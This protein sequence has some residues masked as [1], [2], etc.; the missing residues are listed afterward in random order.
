MNSIKHLLAVG[1]CAGVGVWGCGS[2]ATTNPTGSQ[3]GSAAGGQGGSGGGAT[4][5]GGSGGQGGSGQGGNGQGGS[6]GA[7]SVSFETTSFTVDESEQLVALAVELTTDT[8]L[9]QDLTVAFEVS[10]SATEGEDYALPESFEVTFPEGSESGASEDVPEFAIRPDFDREGDEDVVFA[11]DVPAAVMTGDDA[12]VTI[13]DDDTLVISAIRDDGFGTDVRPRLELHDPSSELSSVTSPGTIGII[14]A[15]S[16]AYDPANDM[17]YIVSDRGQ[18]LFVRVDMSDGEVS[19]VAALGIRAI[20]CLTFD[21]STGTLYGIDDGLDELVEIDTDNGKVTVLGTIDVAGAWEGC[22]YDS[23]NGILYALDD[24]ANSVYSIDTGTAEATLIGE[25][26]VL[27]SGDWEAATFGNGVLYAERNSSDE[28]HSVNTTDGTTTLI[29]THDEEAGRFEGLAYD[30]NSGDLIATDDSNE[31]I[32]TIDT[33]DAGTT[34]VSVLGAEEVESLAYDAANDILYGVDRGG[35]LLVTYNPTNGRLLGGVRLSNVDSLIEALAYDSASNLLFA[36]DDADKVIVTIDPADGTM[37]DLGDP[38]TTLTGLAFKGATLFGT[39]SGALV[40]VNVSDGEAT[41]VGAYNNAS[42]VQGLAYDSNNDRLVALDDDGDVDMLYV[43]DSSDGTDT[44]LGAAGSL[45]VD[46]LA[47]DPNANTLYGADMVR[48]AIVS[49]DDASA[50]IT[51]HSALVGVIAEALAFDSNNQIGYIVEPTGALFSAAASGG[52]STLVGFVELGDSSTEVWGLA[53]NTKDDV[54]FGAGE[55]GENLITIDVT[56][57]VAT[58][59]GNFSNDTDR[60]EALAFD[61]NTETLFGASN[62]TLYTINATTGVATTV[63]DFGD[64]IPDVWGLGYDPDHDILYGS[65]GLE[66]N[67]STEPQIITI[68]VSTGEG[69]FLRSTHRGNGYAAT[70]APPEL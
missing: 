52:T 33:G 3:T 8:P 69:T 49:Y 23:G 4:S 48:D 9:P 12:T 45:D 16:A 27:G 36:Y 39:S 47:F 65:A 50:H 56:T 40:T 31:L 67:E 13:T 41:F 46:G 22:A 53:Y 62:T 57:A 38:G 19:V 25:E 14:D 35:E 7:V 29:G 51:I 26:G 54:L 5:N 11:L 68:D 32:A 21:D 43:I 60:I 66:Q 55:Q 24:S 6:V 42:S 18:D 10:G 2:D 34:F 20:E 59:I 37:T 61:A 1:L 15:E 17:L 30:A 70:F 28:L 58:E 64:G 44:L 63:G